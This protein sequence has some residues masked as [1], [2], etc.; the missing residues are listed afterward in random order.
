MKRIKM[1]SVMLVAAMAASVFAGCGKKPAP[2]SSAVI[3][4]T[5]AATTAAPTTEATTEAT[6]DQRLRRQRKSP[7]RLPSRRARLRPHLP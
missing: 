7:L 3:V 4:S 6:E 1:I 5:P 2:A